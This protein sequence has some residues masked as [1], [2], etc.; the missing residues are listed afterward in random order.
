MA[1]VADSLW[2]H[3]GAGA[4]VPAPPQVQTILALAALSEPEPAVTSVA[5]PVLPMTDA[6]MAVASATTVASSKAVAKAAAA[7][8]AAAKAGA[9]AAAKAVAAP[10]AAAA[11]EAAA[12]AT[13]PCDH[14]EV[15]HGSNQWCVYTTCKKCSERL[16]TARRETANFAGT[17][18][19]LTNRDENMVETLTMYGMWVSSLKP[20]LQGS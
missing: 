9:K 16:S 6:P 4:T 11:P 12:P 5:A 19:V 10:K 3:R 8:K 1:A 2:C 20:R 14:R 7:S 15:R 17:A 18:E 13:P